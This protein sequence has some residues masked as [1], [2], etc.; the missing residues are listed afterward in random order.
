M[1]KDFAFETKSL[2]HLFPGAN[3][4]WYHGTCHRYRPCGQEGIRTSRTRTRHPG[5]AACILCPPKIGLPKRK[6]VNHNFVAGLFVSSRDSREGIYIFQNGLLVMVRRLEDLLEWSSLGDILV[7]TV[8][9]CLFGGR[10]MILGKH[11]CQC[12]CGVSH[13]TF[14]W[15]S[16]KVHVSLSSWKGR[17]IP[18]NFQGMVHFTKRVDGISYLFEGFKGS[19]VSKITSQFFI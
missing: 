16:M 3:G 11:L 1:L 4:S 17:A 6:I 10:M 2:G 12:R 15:V 5:A 19:G 18:N 14:A 13:K 7:L 8:Y 9:V